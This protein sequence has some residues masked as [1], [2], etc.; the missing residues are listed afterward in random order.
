MPSSSENPTVLLPPFTSCVIFPKTL[1]VPQSCEFGQSFDVYYPHGP[2]PT[3]PSSPKK[4]M[5]LWHDH[6]YTKHLLASLA[7][8]SLAIMKSELM[9]ALTL[10]TCTDNTNQRKFVKPCLYPTPTFSTAREIKIFLYFNFLSLRHFLSKKKK[11]T[12]KNSL[13]QCLLHIPGKGLSLISP[14]LQSGCGW[15]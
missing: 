7:R 3:S 10:E 8:S 6:F 15:F 2:F 1:L 11:C 14:Q 9:A 4:C 5:L 13:L 12:F